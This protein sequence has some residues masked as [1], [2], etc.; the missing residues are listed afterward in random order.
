MTIN[1][2]KEFLFIFIFAIDLFL[3]VNFLYKYKSIKNKKTDNIIILISFVA[4][5]I[6]KILILISI[7]RLAIDSV[8]FIN[9]ELY[10]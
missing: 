3:T 6:I 5:S 4:F 2:L 1:T 10:Y 9:L 8:N 7:F